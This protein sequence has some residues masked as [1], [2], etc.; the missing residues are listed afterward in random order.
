MKPVDAGRPTAIRPGGADDADQICA[1]YN[2]Y[3][4]T[5]VI[6]FE[7]EPI[8]AAEMKRRIADVAS[9][10]P[11]LVWDEDDEI[12]GYAYATRWKERSAYR[13]SVETTIYLAADRH[14]GGI[15]TALYAALLAELRSRG[16]HCVIGGIALPN[17]ASVAL[18]EKL[19]FRKIA[20]FE[21]VGWKLG[22]WVDVGYWQ[23]LF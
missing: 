14:G 9:Q 20:H 18:H 4:A 15:G 17:D 7:E 12:H 6:S 10:F 16:V 21:Q 22:R 11:W 3:V 1:I 2:H 5:T 23:L 8:A 13:F 19:G